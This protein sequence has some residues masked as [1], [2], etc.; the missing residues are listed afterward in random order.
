MR[1]CV[2]VSMK[3]EKHH[4][5]HSARSGSVGQSSDIQLN[6]AESGQVENRSEG[7]EE[8]HVYAERGAEVAVHRDMDRKGVMK[9][10]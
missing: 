5:S 4:H 7:Y 10:Y 2:H 1:V 9:K 8:V 6:A 3:V